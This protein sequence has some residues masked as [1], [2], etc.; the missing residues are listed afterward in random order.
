MLPV[1]APPRMARARL[2]REVEQPKLQ[3]GIASC[4]ACEH[5]ILLDGERSIDRLD[6]GAEVVTQFKRG[7]IVVLMRPLGSPL[8][9]WLSAVSISKQV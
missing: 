6:F 9:G 8:E 1:V 4:T 2:A 7:S 3:F 5:A